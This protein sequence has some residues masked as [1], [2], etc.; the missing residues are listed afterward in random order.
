VTRDLARDWLPQAPSDDF[1][2]R[3]TAAVLQ[4]RARS[5]R[6]RA[7]P[8]LLLAAAASVVVATAAWGWTLVPR[9]APLNEAPPGLA[10]ID[11]SDPTP[12]S[13]PHDLPNPPAAIAPRT[14]PV[15][16]VSAP[17]PLVRAPPPKV[18]QPSCKC[19]E[20]A[21]ECGPE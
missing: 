21:C 11:R 2:D 9:R 12:S 16:R 6:P 15:S 4:E 18:P 7:R 20:F 19:N 5:R 3:V 13:L 17:P 14:P 1:A 8:L 10:P